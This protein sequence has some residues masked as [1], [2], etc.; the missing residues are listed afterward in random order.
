MTRR[1]LHC[2]MLMLASTLHVPCRARRGSRPGMADAKPPACAATRHRAEGGTHGRARE[3]GPDW[4]DKRCA[5]RGLPKSRRSC[6]ASPEPSSAGLRS[7]FAIRRMPPT[8]CSAR[9]SSSSQMTWPQAAP[10]CRSRR[11]SRSIEAAR[12][13]I[14][15][16]APSRWMRC[17]WPATGSSW[18]PRSRRPSPR[19]TLRTRPRASSRGSSAAPSASS[20][21]RPH[22]PR[23]AD[24]TQ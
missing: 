18:H 24:C 22:Q 5:V 7:E 10:R 1:A 11:P 9:Y 4:R 13:S 14:A 17:A 15:T 8:I 19:L 3:R 21:P 6:H 2:C 23:I 16:C 20:G 12:S